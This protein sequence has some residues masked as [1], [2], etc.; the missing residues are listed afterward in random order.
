[1]VNSAFRLCLLEINRKYFVF[2]EMHNGGTCIEK[3]KVRVGMSDLDCR[4]GGALVTG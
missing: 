1:M 2:A 4:L 3:T